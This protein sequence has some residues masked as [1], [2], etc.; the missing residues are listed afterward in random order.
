MEPQDFD[1]LIDAQASEPAEASNDEGSAKNRPIADLIA[2]RKDRARTRAAGLAGF[3]LRFHQG[4]SP[5]AG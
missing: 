5:S 4:V 3:G 1:D 2:A